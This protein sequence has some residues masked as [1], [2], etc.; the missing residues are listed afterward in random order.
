MKEVY[1]FFKDKRKI[2]YKYLEEKINEKW[3]IKG[4]KV[5]IL[6]ENCEENRV[7][8]KCVG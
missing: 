3:T 1:E 5:F 4:K 7:Y 6:E 2:S 8:L